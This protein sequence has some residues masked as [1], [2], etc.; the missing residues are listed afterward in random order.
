MKM[1]VKQVLVSTLILS[2]AM[3]SCKKS[4]YNQAPR[5]FVLVHGAWQAPFV[6][7]SVK[8]QLSR[9]GQNVIVVQLPGHGTDST[10]PA[11]ITMNSYRDQIVSAINSVNGKVILVGHSLSG[12]AISAVE[13]EIPSRI[14]KLVFLA[15]YIPSAGQTPYS[16]SISDGQTHVKPPALIPDLTEGLLGIANDSIVPI[17]CPDAPAGLQAKV[18]ANYRP[19]P[20]IPFTDS[21]PITKA[22]FGSADKYYIHTMQDEV[23]GID[24]QD[25]MVQTAGITKVYSLN[26][27]H[28]PFL[29]QPDSVTA[30]LSTIAGIQH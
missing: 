9:A 1:K 22:N 11:T 6:W 4:S 20:A 15:A 16:L 23:I 10:S 2:I 29:S 14:D 21:V 18:V 5:T 3:L 19:D 25:Q 27:S 17:F 26:T 12:F 24:L 30:I 13:E 8:A 7:D 28:C